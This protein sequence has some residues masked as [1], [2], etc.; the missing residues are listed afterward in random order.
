MGMDVGLGLDVDL[1]S[2]FV[3]NVP[4]GGAICADLLIHLGGDRTGSELDRSTSYFCHFSNC[5]VCNPE[6]RHCV[7]FLFGGS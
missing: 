7:I 3:G 2:C 5:L 6:C 4:D 1:G